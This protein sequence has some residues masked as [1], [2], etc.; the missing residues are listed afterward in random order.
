MKTK[1]Y[2][3]VYIHHNFNH[4]VHILI[5]LGVPE[6]PPEQLLTWHEQLEL[7]FFREGG[8]AVYIGA[9]RIIAQKG[10][11]IVINSLE[12][13][14][15][16]DINERAR[17]DCVMIEYVIYHEL[18]REL[19]IKK[20]GSPLS[21]QNACFRNV[22][23]NND[24]LAF[25]LD[26]IVTEFKN[27]DFAND[28][29]IERYAQNL[30]VELFRAEPVEFKPIK[31]DEW[32]V[33]NY[34]RLEPVLKYLEENYTKQIRLDDLATIC[35]LTKCYLCKLFKL[36]TGQT[37]VE[38]INS[39]RLSLANRLLHSTS[40]PIAEVAR[41]AGFDDNCYFS[42]RYRKEFGVSPNKIR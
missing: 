41:Q 27:D 1:V 25:V 36:A 5:D 12:P 22:Y 35:S 32:T 11:I 2:D 3:N 14:L 6:Y 15:V 4:K 10:D 39:L 26:E 19:C 30:I 18:I 29:I 7:L 38:Y 33:L 8:A 13:H 16:R 42:R 40:L 17:Y 21:D 28:I 37:I 23:H 31:D 34:Q 20:Y 9:A 24:R